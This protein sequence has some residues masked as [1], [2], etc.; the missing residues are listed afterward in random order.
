MYTWRFVDWLEL[1]SRGEVSYERPG[2]VISCIL[3]KSEKKKK[4]TDG[5]YWRYWVLSAA[6]QLT[7][8]G[9]CQG[10]LPV[11]VR[12]IAGVWALVQQLLLPPA[13]SSASTLRLGMSHRSWWLTF[14]LLRGC[15]QH[16]SSTLLVWLCHWLQIRFYRF[17]VVVHHIHHICHT[18]L[19][20]TTFFWPSSWMFDANAT[21][22]IATNIA[23]TATADGWQIHISTVVGVLSFSMNVCFGCVKKRG[24]CCSSSTNY[25]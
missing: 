17:A 2:E 1:R 16:G 6:V 25:P 15:V 10:C 18:L 13:A 8:R 14:L 7:R 22:G 12:T 9:C 20:S 11:F 19:F 4:S 23:T 21:S 24:R 5:R 3:S